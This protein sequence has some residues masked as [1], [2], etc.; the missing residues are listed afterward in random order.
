MSNVARLI[1]DP[2][3]IKNSKNIFEKVCVFRNF[4]QKVQQNCELT[5][6]IVGVYTSERK[7]DPLPL[8]NI[9][10]NR[11]GLIINCLDSRDSGG[12]GTQTTH[13]FVVG[14]LNRSLLP[15]FIKIVTFTCFE[16][17]F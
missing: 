3:L 14:S 8:K 7:Q 15:R 6:F 10:K 1:S 2:Q 4:S 12:K 11:L 17:F 5:P 13:K 9:V 16:V